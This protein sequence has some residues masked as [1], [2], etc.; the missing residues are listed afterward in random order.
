MRLSKR[1][2]VRKRAGEWRVYDRGVWADRFPSLE[3]AHTWA[4]QCA[5]AD[6]LYSPGGLTVLAH[7]RKR[8]CRG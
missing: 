6:E 8:A 4:T 2:T 3:A 1:W 5:Y 7:L